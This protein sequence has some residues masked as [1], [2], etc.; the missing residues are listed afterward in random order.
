[1]LKFA[2]LIAAT[3]LSVASVLADARKPFVG[4]CEGVIQLGF[5]IRDNPKENH[6]NYPGSRADRNMRCRAVWPRYCLF[7]PE[8]AS[9]SRASLINPTWEISAIE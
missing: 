5:F 9:H 6:V 4:I 2:C 8:E 7:S 1:M 3:L